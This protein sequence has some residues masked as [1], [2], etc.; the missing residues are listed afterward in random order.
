MPTSSI[1]GIR[2]T[3]CQVDMKKPGDAFLNYMHSQKR[4]LK[5]EFVWKLWIA[6]LDKISQMNDDR[7]RRRPGRLD[8]RTSWFR[9]GGAVPVNTQHTVRG[10]RL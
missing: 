3:V 8:T 7:R 2:Y 5:T 10:G 1:I 9:Y 6:S 4:F